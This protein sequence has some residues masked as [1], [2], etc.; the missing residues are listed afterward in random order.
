MNDNFLAQCPY[1]D[2]SF[3]L[4]LSELEA[5]HG[6][7]RCDVCLQE[8]NATS[9]SANS[10]VKLLKQQPIIKQSPT[11]NIIST[12]DA[13]QSIR[14]QTAEKNTVSGEATAGTAQASV[15]AA[16]ATADAVETETE[17]Q[18]AAPHSQATTQ[19]PSASAAD[20]DHSTA[21]IAAEPN[22]PYA[23]PANPENPATQATQATQATTASHPSADIL[24]DLHT[25]TDEPLSLDWQPDKKPWKRWIMWSLLNALALLLLLSQYTYNNFTQLAHQ[26]NTRPWLE[27]VCPLIGCELP[28][29]VDVQQI[30]SSNLVVRHHPEFKGAL[31]VDAI[32][33]N[34]AAFV[35]PF[36]QL[37]LVFSDQYQQPLA[38]HRF[39]PE[40]YLS[41]ALAQRNQMPT[42][43]PIH[44]AIEVLE[45]EGGAINYN[46]QFVSPDR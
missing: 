37:E 42:Q 30:K 31:Q 39:K 13:D 18:P 36:P 32:I 40:E 34:R 12:L 6:L 27:A 20:Q 38:S 11:I 21:Q 35:Q 9:Q 29:K 33:Y 3:H 14:T 4:V 17:T 24:S 19:T 26:A 44:I 1:C 41:Q 2:N 5:T 10:K 7:A 45:P 43:T 16:T 15:T 25:F 22:Q 23:E 8:F 28:P 46:L